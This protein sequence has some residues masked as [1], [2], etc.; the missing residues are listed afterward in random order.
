MALQTGSKASAKLRY[1]PTEKG[2]RRQR[3]P[4]LVV[5]AQRA[6]NLGIGFRLDGIVLQEPVGKT[7][8][9]V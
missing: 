4:F 6:L 9:R 3:E 8:E 1:R 7:I 2:S 5:L